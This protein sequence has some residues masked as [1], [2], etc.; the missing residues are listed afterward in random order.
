MATNPKPAHRFSRGRSGGTRPLPR[1]FFCADPHGEFD[2][3]NEA[4]LKYRPDAMVLLGDMQAPR[5]LDEILA[6]ALTV[7]QIWWIPGNHDS[8]TEEFY[9]NL[10]KSKLA[11]HKL[12][13]RVANVCGLRIAGLG[14]VFRGQIWMPDGMPNYHS[15]AS[16]IRRIG[17]GNLWRGGLPRRHRTTIF[18]SVYENL[19]RQRAD[20]L[21]T[22]EAPSCHP[23][24]FEAIDRL[25]KDLHAHWLFH[26]HQHEDRT[27]GTY[28]GMLVRGVGY[29][30]IVDLQGRVVV[31]AQIDPR[32]QLA[33]QEAGEEPLPEVLDSVTFERSEGRRPASRRWRHVPARLRK[34]L[35]G[36]KG[37]QSTQSAE[38]AKPPVKD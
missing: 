20:I 33:M 27:Y 7:T 19:A 16:F 21:V 4:A 34:R 2:Y 12:N 38:S 37:A 32:D 1:I 14:G 31:P 36:Q 17:R 6:P 10:W 8:D 26:G 29:R 15:A 3:L 25:A 23:K 13:G 9:D 35:G 30:G 22:H 18:P 11:D 28:K 24:G 5:P